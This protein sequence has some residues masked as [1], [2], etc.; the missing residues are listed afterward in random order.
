MPT[1]PVMAE[2]LAPRMKAMERPN[3]IERLGERP[4]IEAVA[5]LETGR[6]KNNA[7]PIRT[8]KTA[9]VLNCRER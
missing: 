7:T 6:M 4:R 1:Y 9:R 8:T 2:K 5:S 3:R